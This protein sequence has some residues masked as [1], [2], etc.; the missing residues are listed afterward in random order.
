MEPNLIARIRVS[1]RFKGLALAAGVSFLTGVVIRILG[2]FL[3]GGFPVALNIIAG[4]ASFVTASCVLLTANERRQR[5]RNLIAFVADNAAA[6]AGWAP[7]LVIG[8]YCFTT[9]TTP[10]NLIVRQLYES[11]DFL[12]PAVLVLPVAILLV[13]GI[14]SAAPR[15]VATTWTA[16]VRSM[17]GW[18]AALWLTGHGG[19]TLYDIARLDPT[20]A[21]AF[22]AAAWLT[23]MIVRYSVRSAADMPT[24]TFHLP[25]ERSGTQGNLVRGSL[26]PLTER[27]RRYAA[28]HEAGHA[29]LYAALSSLP[30][31]LRLVINDTP[32][33]QGVLG[34]VTPI[35]SERRLIEKTFAE[36]QLLVYLAGQRAE[37]HLM[38]E[39]TNG[40]STDHATWVRLAHEYL[41]VHCAGAY[42]ADPL[43]DHEQRLNACKLDELKA[44]QIALMDGFLGTNLRVLQEVADALLSKS[45]LDRDDVA[46]FLRRVA[47]PDGFPRPCIDQDSPDTTATTPAALPEQGGHANS[48]QP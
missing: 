12:G 2:E 16:V 8:I 10:A 24:Y 26:A 7:F 20:R 43:N 27:D 41:S 35:C 31:D 40:A 1:L 5:L 9:R 38:G 29:L 47:V 33:P 23:W 34:Y 14:A 15:L 46:E 18:A 28:S 25:S 44:R 13:P 6:T 22:A 39:V 36:W 32:D 3:L 11:I 48:T 37:W 4:L 42:Y 21:A 30:Q 17:A 45:A 19:D